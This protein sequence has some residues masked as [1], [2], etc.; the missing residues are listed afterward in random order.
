MTDH[1][2]YRATSPLEETY[3]S[4][5]TLVNDFHG[6]SA[7]FIAR[8]RNL[9]EVEI[10][11]RKAASIHRQLCPS[12]NCKCCGALGQR[13]PQDWEIRKIPPNIQGASGYFLSRIRPE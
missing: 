5:V 10:T 8:G 9:M 4:W 2:G 6:T 13:G 12:A 11:F 3:A 1:T 7:Q